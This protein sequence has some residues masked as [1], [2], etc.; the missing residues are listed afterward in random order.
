MG[1]ALLFF[2]CFLSISIFNAYAENKTYL[3]ANKEY[4]FQYPIDWAENETLLGFDVFIM[5]PKNPD[6]QSKANISIISGKIPEEVD[7][8]MYYNENLKNLQKDIPEMKNLE[9][10]RT[11]IASIPAKWV[12]YE[13]DDDQTEIKHYFF[14]SKGRGYLITCGAAKGFCKQTDCDKIVESFKL[15]G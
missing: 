2:L 10:G 13:R 11:E 3:S 9:S 15:E 14:I 12:K 6:G 7:L 8:D 4:S 5:A 1:N